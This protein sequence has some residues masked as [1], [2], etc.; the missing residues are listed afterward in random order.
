M[1]LVRVYTVRDRILKK[2]PE[3]CTTLSNK[4]IWLLL[5]K[6]VIEHMRKSY[7][8]SLDLS[9]FEASADHHKVSAPS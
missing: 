9:G 4:C 3:N 8:I 5:Q 7:D 2:I 6:K 1:Y